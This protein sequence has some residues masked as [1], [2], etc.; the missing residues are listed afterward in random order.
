MLGA[1]PEFAKR[2]QGVVGLREALRHHV[3]GVQAARPGRPAH[4]GGAEEGRHRGRQHL[5]HRLHD[6]DR[7]PGRARG[8]QEPVPRA[9][10]RPGDPL[11]QG[12]RQGRESAVNEVS[13]ALT[14]EDLTEVPR[15]GRRSTRR[16]RP[17][18][19]R[20]SWTPTTSA[21]PS[22]SPGRPGPQSTPS[23]ALRYGPRP[24][25]TCSGARVNMNSGPGQ[26]GLG[27][28]SVEEGG[29][30]QPLLLE[31]GLLVRSPRAAVRR[32]RPAARSRWRARPS[33]R[34]ADASRSA[35]RD[36]CL[37]SRATAL[38]ASR[39][40]PADAAG[41]APA[42]AADPAA[43]AAS[44]D[45]ADRAAARR[46]RYSSTPRGSIEIC[47]SPSSAHVE[48]VT[49]SRKYRSCETTTRVPGPAVEEV[50]QHRQRL[51]VEVVG[52]LVEQQHVGLGEQQP[53][54]LEAPPLAT[55]EVADPGGQPVAGEA[56]PLQH[57]G[58]GDLPRGPG[59]P[60]HPLHLLHRVE[61]PVGAGRGG[62]A[63]G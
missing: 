21:D 45:V 23:R 35:S 10:H 3:Q 46:S 25:S 1:G 7:Q 51:D 49:R 32:P 61:H 22:L 6:R 53:Q 27:C 57:R 18:W 14:T 17:P 37:S 55:G 29:G 60:G 38:R 5:L 16:T 44:T 24:G 39:S 56:E 15:R 40:S 33:R 41:P 50:L 9:E 58:R 13:K 36:S 52:G 59:Q 20:S 47:P 48:S 62:P 12:R 43:R 31:V 26:R 28:G 30:L 11:L 54:H 63:P 34:A 8:H 4:Q 19:P 2:Y 42:P